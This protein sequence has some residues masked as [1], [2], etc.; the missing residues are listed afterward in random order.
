MTH[1]RMHIH[2]YEMEVI[3]SFISGEKKREEE[4]GGGKN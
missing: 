2:T 1:L 4:R 3:D